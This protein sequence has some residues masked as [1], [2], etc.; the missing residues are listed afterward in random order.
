MFTGTPEGFKYLQAGIADE[1]FMASPKKVEV[2]GLG[3]LTMSTHQHGLNEMN[4]FDSLMLGIE[5]YK[6]LFEGDFSEF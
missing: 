1:M 3:Q 4:S 5:W 2:D 6:K